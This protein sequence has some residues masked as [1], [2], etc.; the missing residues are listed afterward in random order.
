MCF[1]LILINF[2]P[3]KQQFL[4]KPWIFFPKIARYLIFFPP[5]HTRYVNFIH[6]WYQVRVSI[7]NYGAASP[8][9]LSIWKATKRAP[10]PGK[11]FD[12]FA[13]QMVALHD[14]L[15]ISRVLWPNLRILNVW[16]LR[17]NN[18]YMSDHDSNPSLTMTLTACPMG[19]VWP[20]L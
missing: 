1:V 7:W 10:N 9:S 19:L 8:L 20:W 17:G 12:F 11:S 15:Q 14:R 4:T 18:V 2:E 5:P 13:F 16:W 6:P 3:K